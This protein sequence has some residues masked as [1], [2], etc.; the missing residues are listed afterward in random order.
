MFCACGI[1]RLFSVVFRVARAVPKVDCKGKGKVHPRTGNEG[2]DVE[3]RYSSTLSL[4][5]T[6]DGGGWSTPRP[7]RFTPWKDP[8]PIV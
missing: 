6:L 1:R 8:V 2:T 5:S 3:Y 4:T 7:G